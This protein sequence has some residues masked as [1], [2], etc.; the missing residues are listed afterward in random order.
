M[1]PAPPRAPWGRAPLSELCVALGLVCALAGLAPIG[2]RQGFWLLA[3][4]MTLAFLGGLELALR[5]YVA[6]RRARRRTYVR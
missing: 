4:A 1:R 2:S 5:R 3:A 6:A